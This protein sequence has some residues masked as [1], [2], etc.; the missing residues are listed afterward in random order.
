MRE[1]EQEAKSAAHWSAHEYDALFAPEAPKRIALLAEDEQICGFLIASCG[2]E[3]WEIENVAVVGERQR[4]GI[5][6]ALVEELLREA[7]RIGATS[8]LLEVRGSNSAA[9]RLYE[10]AGFSEVG[11]RTAYYRE[12]PEDA[13]VLKI[14]ISFP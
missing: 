10:K 3:E 6:T 13:L 7:R 12:P 2:V 4:S 5:G 14:S 9:R 8:V 11:R 1:L